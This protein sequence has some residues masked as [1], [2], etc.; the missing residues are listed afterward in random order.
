MAISTSPRRK[1]STTASPTSTSEAFSSTDPAGPLPHLLAG[2]RWGAQD[3]LAPA[4][5]LVAIILF[6]GWS[7]L[8]TY[9]AYFRVPVE[10]LG[11]TI[12]EVLAQGLRSILLPGSVIVLAATAPRRSLRV[13]ALAVGLYLLFVGIV[14]GSNHWASPGS[15]VVQLAASIAI[16]AIVFALR[17]G[18]GKT[19]IQRLII[20]AIAVL[21]LMSTPIATGMLDANQKAETT[22]SSLRIVSNTSILPNPATSN[23]QFAYANYVLLKESATRY[24]LFRIGDQYTYSI[25]KSDVLYI[26]Y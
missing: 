11:L 8:A 15:V 19:Q 10:S 2:L 18:F 26:R 25:A 6:A 14:A 21:L 4:A 22:Q 13:A 12:P 23:G 5:V 7:Y 1:A 9:F 3:L 17:L 20:G 16:A 24:W